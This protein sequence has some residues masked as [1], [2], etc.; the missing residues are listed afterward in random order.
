MVLMSLCCRLLPHLF[1]SYRLLDLSKPHKRRCHPLLVIPA[2]KRTIVGQQ[3]NKQLLHWAS[4]N[5]NLIKDCW[6]QDG[7]FYKL[8]YKLSIKRRHFVLFG[9]KDFVRLHF[10][11]LSFSSVFIW[12]LCHS[13]QKKMISKFNIKFEIIS[14]Q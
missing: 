6:L 12:C 4:L 9:Q 10:C 1:F 5:L 3:W 13:N 2:I 14:S 11:S 8:V 7:Q